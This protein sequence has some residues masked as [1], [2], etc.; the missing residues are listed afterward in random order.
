MKNQTQTRKKRSWGNFRISTNCLKHAVDWSLR[1]FR[2]AI[3]N[4]YNKDPES[5]RK[6]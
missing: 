2:N 1:A 5:L 6:G 3:T 4:I